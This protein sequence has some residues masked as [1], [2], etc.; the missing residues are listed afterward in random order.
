M[1]DAQEISAR[2]DARLIQW[3]WLLW[4]NKYGITKRAQQIALQNLRALIN[5]N[6][7][8]LIMKNIE[9]PAKRQLKFWIT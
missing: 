1:K 3:A 4:L 2:A 7:D 6:V 8:D 5:M 9:F